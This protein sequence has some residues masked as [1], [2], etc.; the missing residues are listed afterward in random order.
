LNIKWNI[1]INRHKNMFERFTEGSVKAILLAAREAKKQKTNIVGEEQL[2]NIFINNY[3]FLDK[4]L[5]DL[6]DLEIK[7]LSISGLEIKRLTMLDEDFDLQIEGMVFTSMMHEIVESSIIK[8]DSFNSE[9]VRPG[10]IFLSLIDKKGNAIIKL[11]DL[12][13]KKFNV[14][15]STILKDLLRKE[16]P[17]SKRLK[18]PMVIEF[19]D[20]EFQEMLKNSKNS[21]ISTGPGGFARFENQKSTKKSSKDQGVSKLPKEPSSSI[22]KPNGDLNKEKFDISDF[23]ICLN[24]SAINGLIDP[25][26]GLEKELERVIHILARK[27]KNNPILLGEPGVGKTAV[28]EALALRIA[29]NRVPA[30][31]ENKKILSLDLGA[32]VA[33][34]KYRG[35]FEGRIKGL[36]DV[37]K[38]DNNIILVIDEIHTIIGAGGSEGGL[39]AAN[40]LKPAL[41]RGELQCIGAT[42]LEEYR[43]YIEKDAAFARRFQQVIVEEPSLKDT[44]RILQEISIKYAK[45]HLVKYS[46]ESLA[47]AAKMSKQYIADRFLPDK[48]IDLI[49]EA[50][51]RLQIENYRS[52]D[53]ETPIGRELKNELKNELNFQYGAAKALNYEKAS[54]HRNRVEEIQDLISVI[55]NNSKLE[56]SLELSNEQNDMPIVGASDIARIV[57]SLTGIPVNKITK[58]ESEKLLKMEA[59]L[60]ERLIGQHEAVVSVSNAIRRARVGFRDPNRP[61]ASFIFAGPTGVGK[62]ELT[63]ALASYF[64]GSEETMI[65][66]DMSEYMERHTVA[67]L[68]GSPPGYIGYGE[69]GQLTEAVRSKPYSVVLFDEIEKAH[70]DVF[71]LMLQILEDGRLTDSKGK[72]VNFNNTLIIMTSNAGAKISEDNNYG[73][74]PTRTQD[75]AYKTL[76]AKVNK[77][78]KKA[79]RPEFLNRLDD[80]IVFNQLSKDE[81]RQIADIM[82]KQLAMR[83]LQQGVKLYVSDRVRVKLTDEGFDPV[84]GAR[85]LRRAVTK[86]LE[87]SLAQAFLNTEI[88]PKSKIYMDLNNNKEITVLVKSY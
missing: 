81:I 41:A 33:G 6:N 61:I 32:L 7:N 22:P 62:T 50:G 83:V 66:I 1:N 51:A 76:S 27:S 74:H 57:A 85:P 20:A 59:T 13:G 70:P 23:T 60:H 65:R 2:L 16:E 45:H 21:I 87:D 11:Q 44:I 86:F 38:D 56:G 79:F 75:T 35:E 18:E 46:D 67:K 34:A 48:A 39:D 9:F 84:Y 29:E 88:K 3:I 63:K 49:D 54:I 14:L 12:L 53:S 82:I 17:R 68:I 55:V 73:I 42:T 8:A 36:L 40:L 24:D 52:D 80:I 30:F 64:F 31:L 47:T 15:E 58:T 78:L 43:K 25:V 71:N 26:I 10:H 5:K 72:T 19:N 77:E 69:G 28:V 37:I 4:V